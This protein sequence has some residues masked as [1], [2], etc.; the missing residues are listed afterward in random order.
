MPAKPDRTASCL[1]SPGLT[2][3]STDGAIVDLLGNRLGVNLI[4]V[5]HGIAQV[6]P[7]LIGIGFRLRTGVLYEP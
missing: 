3:A 6:T 1:P 4:L 5:H 7:P 2:S